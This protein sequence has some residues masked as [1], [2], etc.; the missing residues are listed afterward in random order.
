MFVSM[1]EQGVCVSV[2]SCSAQVEQLSVLPRVQTH[3]LWIGN[4]AFLPNKI[5]NMPGMPQ[6]LEIHT[7]WSHSQLGCLS[8]GDGRERPQVA[9]VKMV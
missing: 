7:E 1:R 6:L 2:S 3:S 9:L 8:E 5:P 4:A